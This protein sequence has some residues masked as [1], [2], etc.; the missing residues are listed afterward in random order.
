[1]SLLRFDESSASTH[2]EERA[3]RAQVES[4]RE[5]RSRVSVSWDGPIG[6]VLLLLFIANGA[7]ILASWLLG[8]RL[9]QPLD[10][11]VCFA[12]GRPLLGST[13]TVRGVIAAIALSEATASMMGIA[14]GIGAMIGALAMLGDLG[15]SFLKRRIGIRSSDMAAFVDHLPEALLPTMAVAPL[16]GLSAAD[17]VIVV[18]L[19]QLLEMPLSV[20]LFKLRIRQRPY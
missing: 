4:G 18:A 20:V 16:L 10:C 3:A 12:D 19:F 8:P 15:S 1:M 13:K 17:V 11:G 5:G 9:A 7:P 14:L 2:E 6:L